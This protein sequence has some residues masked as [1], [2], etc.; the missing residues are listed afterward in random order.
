MDDNK[1]DR[2]PLLEQFRRSRHNKQEEHPASPG[3]QVLPEGMHGGSRDIDSQGPEN[4]TDDPQ[5]K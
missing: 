5:L 1:S 2:F 3:S 4:V